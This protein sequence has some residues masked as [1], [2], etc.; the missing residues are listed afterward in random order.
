M[1]ELNAWKL[2][3]F[4]KECQPNELLYLIIRDFDCF[5]FDIDDCLIESS[6]ME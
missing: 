4:P 3:W 5:L 6:E 1:D 2:K